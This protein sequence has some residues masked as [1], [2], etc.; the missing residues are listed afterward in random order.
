[1]RLYYHPASSAS[2]RVT[3]TAHELGMQLELINVGNIMDPAARKALL[4]LN[5]N[6]R[7]PVLED[8]EFVLWESCAIAQYL[9]DLREGQT[10]YP[11]DV[12]AR[13]D[14][15]RW[16]FW[17]TQHWTPAI[18]IIAWERVGKRMFGLGE[19]DPRTMDQGEDELNRLLPILDRSLSERRWICGTEFTLAD[20]AIAG[21]L[22]VAEAAEL[23]LLRHT[24]ICRWFDEVRT[25]RS[26]SA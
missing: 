24:H 23:P 21:P 14:V 19:A 25:R 18:G 16:Q 9:C 26:W 2:K 22:I 17:A 12:R 3:M 15:N 6:G 8:E 7:I 4:P 13:A 10:L 11:S 1:M 20:V 5:P